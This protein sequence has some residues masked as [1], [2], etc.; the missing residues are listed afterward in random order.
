MRALR[1]GDL[2]ESG[3]GLGIFC[4]AACDEAGPW[5]ASRGDYFTRGDDEAV[6]CG[7]CGGPMVLVREVRRLEVIDPDTGKV[8]A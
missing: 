5:A 1:Y 7:A 6:T 8:P 2:P 4:E 3:A